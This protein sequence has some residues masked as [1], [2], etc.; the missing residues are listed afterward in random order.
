MRSLS[1]ILSTSCSDECKQQESKAVIVMTNGKQFDSQRFSNIM[2][3]SS[4]SFVGELSNSLP[5]EGRGSVLPGE[6]SATDAVLNA[7]RSDE[8]QTTYTNW[9]LPLQA[10]TSDTL[11]VGDANQKTYKDAIANNSNTLVLQLGDDLPNEAIASKQKER[12]NWAYIDQLFGKPSYISPK[13]E[14]PRVLECPGNGNSSGSKACQTDSGGGGSSYQG[15]TMTGYG[16]ASSLVTGLG[17]MGGGGGGDGGDDPWRNRPYDLTPSHYD[18][19]F[20]FEDD[21]SLAPNRHA[22]VAASPIEL[23]MDTA[24]FINRL[25]SQTMLFDDPSEMYSTTPSEMYPTTPSEMCPTTPSPACTPMMTPAEESS[26]DIGTAFDCIRLMKRPQSSTV[27]PAT[28]PNV[29]KLGLVSPN[30]LVPRSQMVS[31]MPS[32][33]PQPASA[34]H[35]PPV[36]PTTAGNIFKSDSYIRGE[37]RICELSVSRDGPS[38]TMVMRQRA[39]AYCVNYVM[40][41][42][43]CLEQSCDLKVANNVRA[44]L[45]SFTFELEQQKL[46]FSIPKDCKF[47]YAVFPY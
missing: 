3:R 17:G 41:L 13:D 14:R 40:Q 45:A 6:G 12:S 30:N 26:S 16:L 28:R 37:E 42:K 24:A 36:T 11:I 18:D 23:P 1:V 33:V 8:R 21:E 27:S 32:A 44:K 5:E 10:D 35:C 7:L 9:N 34:T 25:D 22:T 39:L 19:Y 38:E 20:C 43:Q 29:P 15:S 46:V 2:C 31:S 47:L 4:T